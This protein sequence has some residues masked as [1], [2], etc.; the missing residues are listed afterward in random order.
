MFFLAVWPCAKSGIFCFGKL[1]AFY[2]VDMY[3]CLFSAHVKVSNVCDLSI[4]FEVNSIVEI[5]TAFDQMCCYDKM[6]PEQ[7]TDDQNL[8][9]PAG[10]VEP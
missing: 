10:I 7:V 2:L 1:N 3:F 4:L 5:V 8:P 9:M 6:F